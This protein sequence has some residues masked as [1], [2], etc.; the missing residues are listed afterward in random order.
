[1]LGN[2]LAHCGIFK[3]LQAQSPFDSKAT[4]ASTPSREEA[5]AG[6]PLEVF[7][8]LAEES[9]P[10]VASAQPGAPLASRDTSQVM[11]ASSM[12]SM[13]DSPSK[14]MAGISDS[15]QSQVQ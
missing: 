14:S 11:A 9:P 4:R 12:Q 13:A 1:M 15:I 2:P 10:K 3:T 5:R 7:A 6:D 8:R